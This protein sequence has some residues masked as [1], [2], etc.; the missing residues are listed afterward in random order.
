MSENL[1]VTL[2]FALSDRWIV[3]VESERHFV[4]VRHRTRWYAVARRKGHED[5]RHWCASRADALAIAEMIRKA[6][7]QIAFAEQCEAMLDRLTPIQRAKA[8]DRLRA[9]AARCSTTGEHG[10]C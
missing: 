1:S 2:P 6:F 5:R 8:I 4:K 9:F 10:D 7:E 3:T